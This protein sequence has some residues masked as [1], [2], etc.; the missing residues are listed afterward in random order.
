MPGRH[1]RLYSR[2]QIEKPAVPGQRSAAG[3]IRSGRSYCLS[4][5]SDFL[6]SILSILSVDFLF[7]FLSFFV[8][9]SDFPSILSILSWADAVP[10]VEKG[11]RKTYCE[12][13]FHVRIL[14]CD[15]ER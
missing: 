4:I 15:C 9:L 2:P 5:L 7:F 11:R 6:S 8:I 1:N 3:E 13:L 14:L 12:Y 10:R